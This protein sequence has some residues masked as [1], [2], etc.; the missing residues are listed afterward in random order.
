MDLPSTS[1]FLTVDGD[2][3]DVD[4]AVAPSVQNSVVGDV[5]AWRNLVQQS[6][7]DLEVGGREGLGCAGCRVAGTR[8]TPGPLPPVVLRPCRILCGWSGRC[9]YGRGGRPPSCG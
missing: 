1:V 9:R 4:A 6:E 8:A 5:M 7:D 2:G 3:S